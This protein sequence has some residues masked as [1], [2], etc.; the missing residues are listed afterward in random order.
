MINVI[1]HYILILFGKKILMLKYLSLI[2]SLLL[3]Y[4]CNSQNN[5]VAVK[6]I[7]E[8]QHKTDSLLNIVENMNKDSL[9]YMYQTTSDKLN[10][11]QNLNTLLP[12]KTHQNIVSSWSYIFKF[13]KKQKQK[14]AKFYYQLNFSKKQLKDLKEDIENGVL[15]DDKIQKY[16]NDETKALETTKTEVNTFMI[17][18]KKE[19]QK[20]YFLLPQINQIIDSIQ[21]QPAIKRQVQ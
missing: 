4:S 15:S 5:K 9:E 21:Q 12:N 20:F 14:P 16:T 6:Q 8:L 19:K 1:Y 17:D 7:N 13:F 3:L 11:F 18:L 10:F 2:M